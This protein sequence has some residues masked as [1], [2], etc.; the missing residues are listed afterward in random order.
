M[1]INRSV[2]GVFSCYLI[3]S[4]SVRFKLL[5]LSSGIFKL[6]TFYR[7]VKEKHTLRPPQTVSLFHQHST[8][9]ILSTQYQT[10]EK[11]NDSSNNQ[12][13]ETNRS[14]SSDSSSDSVSEKQ[15]SVRTPVRT[16]SKRPRSSPRKSSPSRRSSPLDDRSVSKRHRPLSSRERNSR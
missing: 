5:L 9:I 2:D 13:S 14:F 7:H 16:S 12:S 8:A 11:E 1:E 10:H 15:Q 3:C 4:C 6:S